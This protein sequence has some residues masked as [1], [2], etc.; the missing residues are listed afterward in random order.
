MRKET[1]NVMKKKY[2]KR[3][4]RRKE[5]QKELKERKEK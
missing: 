1:K 4:I 3:I 5:V 2:R